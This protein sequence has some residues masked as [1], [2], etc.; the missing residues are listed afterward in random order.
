MKGFP[1]FV[2]TMQ[3]LHHLASDFPAETK[4]YLEDILTTKDHWFTVKELGPNDVEVED[5]THRVLKQETNTPV[6]G[7]APEV[8][9]YYQELREDP[10][11]ALYRLGFDNSQAV[12]DY[13]D[14]IQG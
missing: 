12:L 9:Y 11:G 13:I 8:H 14:R 5:S 7:A 4:A 3:D 2:N 6:E 10:N 1:K